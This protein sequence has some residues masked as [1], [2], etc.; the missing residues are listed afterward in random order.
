MSR[1]QGLLPEAE[2]R[3][4]RLKLPSGR[5]GLLLSRSRERKGAIEDEKVRVFF[6]FAAPA[7]KYDASEE[8]RR[9]SSSHRYAAGPSFSRKRE[10]ANSA[11]D[12]AP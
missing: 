4:R 10:K 6:L 8:E 11:R 12:P 1:Q 3:D 2:E 7:K 5:L 9:P